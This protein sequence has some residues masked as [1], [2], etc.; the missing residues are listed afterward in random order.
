MRLRPEFCFYVT[1][2]GQTI[3]SPITLGIFLHESYTLKVI[4]K[5]KQDK[6]RVEG[7]RKK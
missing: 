4:E 7:G 2:T 1:P 6:K 5:K 3:S